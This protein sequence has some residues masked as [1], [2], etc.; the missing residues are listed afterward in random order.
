[1]DDSPQLLLPSMPPMVLFL[2][3]LS[4]PVLESLG[5][6]SLLLLVVR[7]VVFF[8]SCQLIV[9]TTDMT[10]F[11]AGFY[12]NDIFTTDVGRL[13]NIT[14]HDVSFDTTTNALSVTERFSVKLDALWLNCK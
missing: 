3:F 5:K 4:L 13:F 11:S 12:E 1:M 2:V 10:Y 7:P 8:L 9:L 14:F 6:Q